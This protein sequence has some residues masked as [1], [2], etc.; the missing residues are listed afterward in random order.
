MGSSARSVTGRRR[1]IVV[2][3]DR[4]GVAQVAAVERSNESQDYREGVQG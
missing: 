2:T 4:A 1:D 3:T